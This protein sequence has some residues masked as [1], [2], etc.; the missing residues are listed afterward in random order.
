MLILTEASGA[1]TQGQA[2][3]AIGTGRTAAT[4]LSAAATGALFVVGPV[5]PFVLAASCAVV[6]CGFVAWLWRDVEG[7]SATVVTEVAQAAGH[8]VDTV[9]GE[10]HRNP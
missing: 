9:C 7:R 5:I 6:V 2:Q 3:G 4:A 10:T 1:E 8:S